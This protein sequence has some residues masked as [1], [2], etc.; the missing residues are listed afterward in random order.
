MLNVYPFHVIYII[1]ITAIFVLSS[2]VSIHV[3]AQTKRA[4]VIGIG[5]QLDSDWNKING[6]KDVSLVM[7]ILHHAHFSDITSL[8]NEQATK[9]QIKKA[10]L[11]LAKKSS[12]GD[13]IY[14]HFSGHG[15]QMID[16]NG[17]EN[18]RRDESWIPYD[19]YKKPCSKDMGEKH[20]SDDEVAVVLHSIKKRIGVTGKILVVVDA[21][22][23]GTATWSYDYE[24][25]SIRGTWEVFETS[26]NI[27]HSYSSNIIPQSWVTISACKDNQ[28]NYE[29][30]EKH[31]GK[32][33]YA[34]YE[35]SNSNTI[36]SNKEFEEKL[37]DFFSKNK[38][39]YHQTPIITGLT[40]D[41]IIQ[42]IL[43]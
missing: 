19:A 42:D 31:I 2:L 6:D 38:G 32:L 18:D 3:I 30:R 28:S 33:T 15:Q 21:C 43:K 25:E 13:I 37:Y 12:K 41:I 1:K 39:K 10:L 34:L 29:L 4:V 35:I 5:S 7:E 11:N 23:S 36:F 22:H 26:N 40:N 17:D 9:V 16:L 24:K 14:I 27:I 8:V 20:L